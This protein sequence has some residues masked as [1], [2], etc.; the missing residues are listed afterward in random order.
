MGAW[1]CL[2]VLCECVGTV[3]WWITCSPINPF[4]ECLLTLVPFTVLLVYQLNTMKS[5]FSSM[6]VSLSN[7]HTRSHTYTHTHRKDGHTITE[8]CW[9]V[10]VRNEGGEK[11]VVL[12]HRCSLLLYLRLSTTHAHSHTHRP[13]LSCSLSVKAPTC[14]LSLSSPSPSCPVSHLGSRRPGGIVPLGSVSC[15]M[16]GDWWIRGSMVAP[17][18]SLRGPVWGTGSIKH[19]ASRTNGHALEGQ[20]EVRRQRC[21][22]I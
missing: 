17:A 22:F 5:P 6:L 8:H 3:C 2:C 18:G 7:T 10:C 14:H 21:V 4:A 16:Q 13:P 20:R 9:R 19:Q 11:E 1:L 12:L 15:Q